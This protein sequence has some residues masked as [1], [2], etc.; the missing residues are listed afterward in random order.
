MAELKI[1]SVNYNFRRPTSNYIISSIVDCDYGVRGGK[2]IN[3]SQD[4]D[5]LYG[6]LR[7]RLGFMELLNAGASLYLV[8]L[9][10]LGSRYPT[11][12]LMN[13][14]FKYCHPLVHDI[15]PDSNLDPEDD[16]NISYLRTADSVSLH[17]KY[18]YNY[19]IDFTDSSMED[20]DF[21]VIP[22]FN[23]ENPEFDNNVIFYFTSINSQN[24]LD[25]KFPDDFSPPVEL[26]TLGDRQIAFNSSNPEVSDRRAEFIYKWYLGLLDTDDQKYVLVNGQGDENV[27]P[28][29]CILDGNK[30][31]LVF[32]KPVRNITYLKSSSYLPFKCYSDL[33]INQELIAKASV[34]ESILTFKSKLIGDVDIKVNLIHIKGFQFEVQLSL[35]SY[36]ESHYVTLDKDEVFYQGNHL[37]IEEVINDQS[38]IAEVSVHLGGRIYSEGSDKYTVDHAKLLEGEYYI[39]YGN[40]GVDEASVTEEGQ[41]EFPI[42]RSLDYMVSADIYSNLFMFEDDI[43]LRSQ[44]EC[45]ERLLKS[46][47]TV[48]LINIPSSAISKEDIESYINYDT[49]ELI[50]YSYGQFKFKD[51]F[52]DNSFLYALNSISGRF[53]NSI[54]EGFIP[55]GID[56][57]VIVELDNLYINHVE[58]NKD[59][60]FIGVIRNSPDYMDP[61]YILVYNYVSLYLTRFLKNKIGEYK[62][63]IY[64]LTSTEIANINSYS[65]LIERLSI[66]DF[67]SEG[68]NLYF[69]FDLSISG[70]IGRSINIIININK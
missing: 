35:E 18:T 14:E 1:K 7:N 46:N 16:L 28:E 19:V 42:S 65:N 37:F 61:R 70:L 55:E 50:L 30:V 62:D 58:S 56:E 23:L 41:L 67:S 57:A 38:L 11:L 59:E 36:F 27:I 6:G 33:Y 34:E 20:E 21:V 43:S 10:K 53:K 13:N 49:R 32:K 31:T 24:L 44:R 40:E 45:H 2:I 64:R 63:D 17:K 5:I 69:K 68:N 22:S 8:R 48:G 29:E 39:S 25:R 54:K 15:L 3:S 12:R 66:S 51:I 9:D 60:Y 52:L 26:R 4:L 47:Y